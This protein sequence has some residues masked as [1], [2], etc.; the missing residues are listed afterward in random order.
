[1]AIHIGRL[2]CRVTVKTGRKGPLLH[3]TA[4]PAKPA[5]TFAAKSAEPALEGQAVTGG[6]AE[7]SAPDKPAVSARQADV[8]A[9]TDRVYELMQQEIA[10]ARLRGGAGRKG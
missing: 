8:R 9:V 5:M 4:R 2:R 7:P 3:A 6:R 10:M 1:M